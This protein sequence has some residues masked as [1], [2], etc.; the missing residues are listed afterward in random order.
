MASHRA[1]RTAIRKSKESLPDLYE[2][3]FHRNPRFNLPGSAGCGTISGKVTYT[4]KPP[5]PKTIDM[6]SEP[7][8]AK[9]Y[10]TPPVMETIVT[11]ANNV[12]QNVVVF[13]SAGAPDDKAPAQPVMLSQKGCRY[14]PHVAAVVTGQEM[15]ILNDDQTTH[16]VHPLA[17]EN[18]EWNRSQPPGAPPLTVKFDKPEFIP[19]KCNVHPWMRGYIV[20]LNTSKYAVTGTDGTFVLTKSASGQIHRYGLARRFWYHVA[21]HN[22]HRS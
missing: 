6:S 19:V 18:R 5:Q 22:D 17:K 10:S 12:L 14:A 15:K 11:G 1:G 16:N 8:C 9:E 4:G 13:I 21:R 20:V 2:I 3:A 7:G